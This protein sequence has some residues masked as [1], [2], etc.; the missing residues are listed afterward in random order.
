MP[1]QNRPLR[2]GCSG[3]T[4][5]S[6]R[7]RPA[8]HTRHQAPQQLSGRTAQRRVRSDRAAIDLFGLSVTKNN[9]TVG[10]LATRA[11]H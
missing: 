7:K 1:S 8:H 10:L 6:N 5:S 4:I 2:F 9:P 11:R 3:W